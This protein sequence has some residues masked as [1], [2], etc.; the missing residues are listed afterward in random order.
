MTADAEIADF[1]TDNYAEC[2]AT[3]GQPGCVD[4]LYFEDS[5]CRGLYQDWVHRCGFDGAILSC[6]ASMEFEATYAVGDELISCITQ[7]PVCADV[8]G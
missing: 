7:D 3:M 1:R 8:C 4:C 5:G 2:V 6:D